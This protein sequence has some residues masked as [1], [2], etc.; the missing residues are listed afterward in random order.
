MDKESPLKQI[1]TFEGD[2]ALAIERQ[3]ESLVSIQRAEEAK[4][5]LSGVSVGIPDKPVEERGQLLLL[6]LGTLVL[7]SVGVGGAWYTY[8]EYTKQTT[9]PEIDAPESR[10]IGINYE[11][12]V[13]LTRAD[14]ES[15][16]NLFKNS[17]LNISYGEI[18]HIILNKVVGVV[19]NTPV[20]SS[21]FFTI[22][23]GNAPGYLIRALDPNFMAG[24]T[25]INPD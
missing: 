13:D 10:L 23:S 12:I 3:N 5:G 11:V 8:K 6:I 18:R 2:V 14:R 17:S 22:L 25:R 24:V 15:L 16:I 20:S 1:R 21:D 9:V 19:E 4:R 7:L